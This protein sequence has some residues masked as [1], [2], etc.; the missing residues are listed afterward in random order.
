MSGVLEEFMRGSRTDRKAVEHGLRIRKYGQYQDFG[1][2]S[3][4]DGLYLALEAGV[5]PAV[6]SRLTMTE[7]RALI[8]GVTD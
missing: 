2:S 8:I 3:S 4:A 7:K 1:C 5:T 6:V